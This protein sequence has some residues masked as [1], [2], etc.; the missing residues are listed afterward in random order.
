MSR[1]CIMLGVGLKIERVVSVCENHAFAKKGGKG[2][3]NILFFNAELVRRANA[4]SLS[5]EF[6]SKFLATLCETELIYVRK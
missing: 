5:D 4:W 6:Q 2:I 3:E 1:S